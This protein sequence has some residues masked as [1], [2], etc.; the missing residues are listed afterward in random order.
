MIKIKQHNSATYYQL[1]FILRGVCRATRPV[2]YCTACAGRPF[3][4]GG[5]R[6]MLSALVHIGTL[7]GRHDPSKVPLAVG[8][9]DPHGSLDWHQWRIQGLAWGHAP[10]PQTHDTFLRTISYMH[11][12]V[13][14]R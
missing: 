7:L 13:V 3:V 10:L 1:R 11:M 6:T 2:H 4:S 14:W 8:D 12:H 5:R 9:L